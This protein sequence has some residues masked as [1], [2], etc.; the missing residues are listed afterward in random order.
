M[1]RVGLVGTGFVAA[2]RAAVLDADSRV[3]LVAVA[4]HHFGR[5]QAFVQPLGVVALP[6]W[7]A[8]VERNDIDLVFVSTI[9]R[10]HGP[11]AAAA[12]AAEKAV[13]V[14]YPL[15]LDVAEAAALVAQ[16]REQRQVLHVE[17]IELLGGAHQ[18]LM[19]NLPSLGPPHYA[20]YATF[21]PRT[22]AVPGWTYCP[23]LFGFPLVGAL[24]RVMRLVDAFGAV[25]TVACQVRYADAHGGDD[26]H[27]YY[28][29]CWC[30]AQ[31]GFANGVVADLTY[32]KG[33]AIWFEARQLAVQCQAG[34][35]RFED[36]QG[37]RRDA[38]GEQPVVL[39]SRRGAFAEDTRQVIDHLWEG[40]ALYGSPEVSLYALQVADGAR[41]A[42]ATGAVVR[43][44]DL[45][46]PFSSA[47][48]GV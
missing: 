37:W 43:L 32:G 34:A 22:P 36:N 45:P 42:A 25:D 29:T 39:G 7:Q 35:L 5:T 10:D 38:T 15:S 4:G 27:T 21:A 18:A 1:L 30:T 8:L 20:R 6:H 46:S 2:R 14:D 16:A 31:L 40:R 17:H 48:T 11:V 44:D 47:S 9:N 28:R 26:G 12:L 13:V 24:S 19:A 3:S 33:A 23:E 41:R